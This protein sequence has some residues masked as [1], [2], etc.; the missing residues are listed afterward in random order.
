MFTRSKI[1]SFHLGP[2]FVP[3]P[4]C[5]NDFLQ[6]LENDNQ[7][8]YNIPSFSGRFTNSS[9]RDLKQFVRFS[10]VVKRID[11]NEESDDFSVVV[12][13]LH[14]NKQEKKNTHTYRDLRT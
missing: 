9:N 11:F 13:D 10:T 14:A 12:K 1:I 4:L 6:N 2:H 3:I 8:I 5:M 7:H